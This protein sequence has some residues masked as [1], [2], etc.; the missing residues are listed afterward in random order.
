MKGFH[1]ASRGPLAVLLVCLAAAMAPAAPPDAAESERQA[2]IELY[3]RGM[4][5]D[6]LYFLLAGQ[7][8]G[9]GA[10]D[11]AMA[12]NLAIPTPPAGAFR[13]SVLIQRHR[14][15]LLSGL[16]ADAAGL[17]DSLP[18][19]SWEYRVPG[20]DM[21]PAPARRTA[22]WSVRIR[23]G[24]IGEDQG[25]ARSY[26]SGLA[27]PGT[28]TGGWQGSSK[29]NLDLPLPSPAGVPLSLGMGYDIAKSY[30][31][32]SPDY[33][34]EVGLRADAL[35]GGLSASVSLGAGRIAGRGAVTSW[36]GDAT[37]FGMAGSGY[38][39]GQGGYESEWEGFHEQR[40]GAAW[41]SLLREWGLGSGW[42]LRGSLAGT[43]LMLD[44][45]E[46]PGMGNVIFVDD[47]SKPRPVHF[48]DGSFRDT[49]PGTGIAG[50]GRYTQ[51]RD[52]V[53]FLCPQGVLAL[54]PGLAFGLPAALG[55]RAELAFGYGFAFYPAAYAWREAGGGEPVPG[56]TVDFRG[57][58]LNRADG[59][60]YAAFLDLRNGGFD[61]SYGTVP[62]RE[63]RVRRMDHS[64]EA[65]TAL[66]RA[67]GRWGELRLEIGLERTLSNLSGE[68]P[69]W[70]PEW[71][72]RA[73]IRWSMAGRWPR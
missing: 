7:A 50:Y 38:W 18:I 2:W 4:S 55:A 19:Q 14:L 25:P 63:R 45:L 27:V 31:K 6:S 65:E 64:F 47:V 48:R 61:E 1:A 11:T 29:G 52:S 35:P 32:D 33:R 20:P 66:A 54:R 12:F 26:P 41:L 15:Y 49:V 58:A 56:D 42:S 9:G 13:D 5:L 68:A 62:L 72:Y 3:S 28:D 37:W 44:P 71:D 30:Y 70:I 59:R 57:Y 51:A 43:L 21:E 34:A 36:K 16:R 53:P 8:L 23:S 24:F 46:V 60:Y 69:I 67:L 10:Y 17:K 22:A 40:Y 39:V 73:G